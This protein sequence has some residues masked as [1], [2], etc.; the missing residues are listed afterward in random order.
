MFR[1]MWW[2]TLGFLLGVIAIKRGPELMS[3]AS[4]SSIVSGVWRW[5]TELGPWIVSY[6]RDQATKETRARRA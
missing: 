3:K 6:F 4:F 1:R 2:F 5:L